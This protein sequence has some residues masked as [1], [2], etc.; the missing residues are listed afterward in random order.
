MILIMTVAKYATFALHQKGCSLFFGRGYRM[1]EEGIFLKLWRREA[2]IL[3]V[4]VDLL[5]LL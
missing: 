5:S 3:G 1:W 2:K 4:P